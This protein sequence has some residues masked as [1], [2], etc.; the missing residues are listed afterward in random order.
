M[1]LTLLVAIVALVLWILFGFV[2]PA[3]T[4]VI[5][6]LF[7]AA[8]MLLARRVLVGKTKFLS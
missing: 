1:N 5:H 4:G 2:M 8:V 3:G 7:A 6:L